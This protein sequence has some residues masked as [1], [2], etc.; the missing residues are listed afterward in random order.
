MGNGE[1]NGL[2]VA[3]R[4]DVSGKEGNDPIR[5]VLRFMHSSDSIINESFC[6]RNVDNCYTDE[7]IELTKEFHGTEL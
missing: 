3:R 5:C 1:I 4:I 7:Y 2:L 6:I